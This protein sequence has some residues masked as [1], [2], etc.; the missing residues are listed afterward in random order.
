MARIDQRLESHTIIG[1]DTTIFIYHLEA[2]PHYLE[3]TKAVLNGVQSGQWRAVTSTV[4][5]LELTVRPWRMNRPDIAREYEAVLANFPNLHLADVSRDVARRAAQLRASYNLRP[6]DA[7]QIA[8]ALI[9][10]ATVWVS[11]DKKLRRLGP[12]L[13]VIILDEFVAPRR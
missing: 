9:H 13:D 8:A 12:I 6:A 7:L 2:H 1:L 5:I 11:N 3:L 10:Q 4:T